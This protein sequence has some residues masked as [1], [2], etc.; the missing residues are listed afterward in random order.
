MVPSI[1]GALTGAIGKVIE[2]TTTDQG[3][4]ALVVRLTKDADMRVYGAKGD[5]VIVQ[6]KFVEVDSGLY[7][8]QVNEAPLE[9]EQYRRPSIEEFEAMSTEE[10]KAAFERALQHHHDNRRNW[11]PDEEGDSA[12][13]L[14]AMEELMKRQADVDRKNKEFDMRRQNKDFGSAPYFFESSEEGLGWTDEELAAHLQKHPRGV[15]AADM[16]YA[17]GGHVN[18]QAAA[19]DAAVAR[20]V[21]KKNGKWYVFDNEYVGA[22]PMREALS[23]EDR[24]HYDSVM[25]KGKV[26]NLKGDMGPLDGMEGPFQFRSGAVLY[27]D[28]KAGKYYDRGK[29]MYLDND[30]AAALIMEYGM[31]TKQ[32]TQYGVTGSG[33]GDGAK[34]APALPANAS[35]MQI[36]K[37]FMDSRGWKLPQDKALDLVMHLRSA[38]AKKQEDVQTAVVDFIQK[39]NISVKEENEN[40]SAKTEGAGKSYLTGEQPQEYDTVSLDGEEYEVKIV[41]GNGDVDISRDDRYG[42]ESLTISPENLEFIS[43]EGETVTESDMQRGT[44]DGM[45]RAHELVKGAQ[46]AV[47]GILDMEYEPTHTNIDWEMV[48]KALSEAMGIMRQSMNEDSSITELEEGAGDK[49]S[50][51]RQIVA[52]SQYGVVDGQEVDLYSASAVVKVIDA[53]NPQNKEKY[54]ALPVATMVEM[55]FK[56]MKETKS[57]DE[58]GDHE[59]QARGGLAHSTHTTDAELDQIEDI[60]RDML[61]AG[62]QNSRIPVGLMSVASALKAQGFDASVSSGVLNIDGAYFMGK[63]SKFE[64][65]P[66]EDVRRVGE[67]VIGRMG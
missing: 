66:G 10:R 24:A 14:H 31:N 60:A 23:P 55:A 21:A 15:T 11:S 44:N 64:I 32:K 48:V 8:A 43:R 47:D 27:Y 30:E 20:G 36:A 35:P 57:L 39:N 53:L 25:N 26:P 45:R 5:E 13:N 49:E 9:E 1:G 65:A 19:L 29:D 28:T 54:L 33:F 34:K 37:A 4:P 40:F 2:L 42:S 58:Y 6:P 59:A 46:Q 50:A 52:D 17:F 63:A 51:L 61:E 18:T 67:Y 7:G 16:A 56:M 22:S 3:S 41:R 62:I 12:D 38:K